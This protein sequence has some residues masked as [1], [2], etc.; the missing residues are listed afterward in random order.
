MGYA[1]FKPPDG[2]RKAFEAQEVRFK[3]PAEH[4]VNGK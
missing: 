3:F 1:I 2:S 4:F